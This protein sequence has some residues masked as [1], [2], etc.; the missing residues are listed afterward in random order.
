MI[1]ELIGKDEMVKFEWS[2]SSLDHDEV[3]IYRCMLNDGSDGYYYDNVMRRTDARRFW[4]SL[5]GVGFVMT[6][7]PSPPS[8]EN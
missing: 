1:R 4:Q 5:I 7:L 2:V 6:P 8:Y 3:H